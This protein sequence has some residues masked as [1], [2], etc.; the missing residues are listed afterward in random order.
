ME[1]DLTEPPGESPGIDFGDEA[2][3][4]CGTLWAPSYFVGSAGNVSAETIRRHIE[5]QTTK[6]DD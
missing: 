6:G 4:V 2:D 1:P 5:E 3:C